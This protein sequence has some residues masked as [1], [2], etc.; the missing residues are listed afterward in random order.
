VLVATCALS[1]CADEERLVVYCS[2]D[3]T[4]A[5]EVL[6][7][8]EDKT[9]LTVD[10]VFDTEAG[11]TTGL[12]KRIRA[13]GSSPRAD[14]W[15]SGELFH[16]IALGREGLLAGYDSPAAADIPQLYRDPQHRWTAIGLRGRVLA[17]DSARVDA[18]DLPTHWEQLSEERFAARTAFANPLFGTTCGH[19]A[20]MFALWGEERGRAFLTNLRSNGGRMVDG[21][22][23]AVRAVLDGQ[24]AMC[25]TDT[26]DVR[27]AQARLPSLKQRFLDLGDGGTL[28][29]PS[30]VAI[31][32]NCAHPEQAERLVDFLVSAEVERM[33]AESPSGNIPVRADLCREL[34]MPVPPTTQ[35]RYEQ[36]VDSMEGATSAV[37][38]ILIR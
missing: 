29:V 3:E 33:L 13:E 24:V 6:S 17:Y 1:G 10:A 35:L 20:A 25:M 37:R 36:I 12:V 9:G 23:A 32:Q 5:R 16:T 4:F 8:F 34:D 30:S 14:V 38:E 27:V 18:K 28:L 21:N 31:L 7:R 11:K 2:V 15:F 26:D 19:V 22:S